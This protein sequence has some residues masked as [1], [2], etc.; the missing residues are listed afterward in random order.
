MDLKGF[1][2]NFKINTV[3]GVIQ[4]TKANVKEME[5]W[6]KKIGSPQSK[7]DKYQRVAY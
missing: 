5:G 6:I 3:K 2:Y 7:I 1:V 4:G